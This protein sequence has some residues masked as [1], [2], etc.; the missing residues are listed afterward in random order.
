[1]MAVTLETLLDP[2]HT[3]MILIEVQDRVIGP[4]APWPQLTEAAAKVGLIQNAARL[5]DA[6]R[7]RGAPVIH[8]TAEN[9][10]NFFGQNTNARL[11]GNARKRH[12]P[13]DELLD[14][15]NKDVWKD[16]DLLLPRYHGT[17]PMTGTQL[18]TVLRNAGIKTVVLTG[19]SI[20]FAILNTTF[21]AVNRSYQVVV[22]HDAVAGFPEDYAQG[23]LKNT[24]FMLGTIAS[25]DDILKAMSTQS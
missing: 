20:C 21:D 9:L 17:S 6:M 1:M 15:P 11:F 4:K 13:G 24:I 22:P 3:T 18:D 10:P 19:V 5:A 2:K 12:Q 16:G 14:R 8:C 25:T 7:S 23:V